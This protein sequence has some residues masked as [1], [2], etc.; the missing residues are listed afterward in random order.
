MDAGGKGKNGMIIGA[1]IHNSEHVDFLTQI[2]AAAQAGIRSIRSYDLEYAQQAAPALKRNGMSLLG[3]IHVDGEA[4]LADWRS[5]V[6]LDEIAR[7]HDLGIPLEGICV[8]NELREGR[9]S[10]PE[11][12]FS[13]RLSFAMANLIAQYR[14][15]LDARG[16]ST[17]LTYASEGIV[18]N[19]EGLFHE[20]M[21]PLIDACHVV[22]INMYPMDYNAWFTLGAFHESQRLLQDACEQKLRFL[23]FEFKLRRVLEQLASVKKPLLLSET[24]FPSAAGYHVENETQVVPETDNES[25]GQAMRE[26]MDLLY[27]VNADYGWNIVAAYIYEWWD[28]FHHGAIDEQSPIH[29]AFGLCDRLGN[30]KLDIARVFTD[31]KNDTQSKG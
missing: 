5:Q 16:L 8:G 27:E 19:E 3:G 28:N 30:P 14:E 11:K 6:R 10:S 31:R 2:D 24:G 29:M 4:L 1:W 26:F 20:W 12:K 13:A 22:S 7:Y 18:I 23:S 25:F 21:W 15:W 9:F 17:P